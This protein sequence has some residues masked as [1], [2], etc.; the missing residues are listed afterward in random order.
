M[1]L[2]MP[3]SSVCVPIWSGEGRYVLVRS[4]DVR[5][6]CVFA[7]MSQ[8]SGAVAAGFLDSWLWV[9]IE[10]GDLGLFSFL[11]RSIREEF[12]QQTRGGRS[13]PYWA[14]LLA[15]AGG[16]CVAVATAQANGSSPGG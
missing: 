14:L 3:Y 15:A 11:T 9:M 6:Y 5:S 13:A 1:H 8:I 16:V 4:S 2:H 12:V 7:L 10:R